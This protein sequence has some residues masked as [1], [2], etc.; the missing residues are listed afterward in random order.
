MDKISLDRYQPF[1]L[2]VNPCHGFGTSRI[3]SIQKVKCL[4]HQCEFTFHLTTHLHK[5]AVMYHI[6]WTQTKAAART[7]GLPR[8]SSPPRH[9][10]LH[11][12]ASLHRLHGTETQAKP[13]RGKTTFHIKLHQK[14]DNCP[15][16]NKVCQ[17]ARVC[18][19]ISP[20]CGPH[21]ILTPYECVCDIF[22]LHEIGRAS[23]RE[24]V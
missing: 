20:H 2:L 19:E 4:L 8:V 12:K 7:C 1:N 17:A 22:T 3:K 18:D 15:A 21:A 23:C 5:G 9:P 11:Q 16:V 14:A 13:G 6:I 24:R 10:H